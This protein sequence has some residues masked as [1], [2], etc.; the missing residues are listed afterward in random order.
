MEKYVTLTPYITTESKIMRT[1]I[2]STIEFTKKEIIARLATDDALGFIANIETTTKRENPSAETITLDIDLGYVVRANLR[3]DKNRSLATIFPNDVLSE[4][5]CLT[6]KYPLSYGERP[7][8]VEGSIHTH[9]TYLINFDE[10][11]EG[12]EKLGYWITLP[13][14]A[15]TADDLKNYVIK[16][17]FTYSP[18]LTI[19]KKLD[20]DKKTQKI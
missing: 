3:T 1:N 16:H 12:I 13:D 4:A 2:F 18:T 8:G 7:E 20:Y 10:F 5:F 17:G 14:D 15:R 11:I 6:I 9:G 19:Q